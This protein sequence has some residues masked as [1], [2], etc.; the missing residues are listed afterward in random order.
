MKRLWWYEGGFGIVGDATDGGWEARLEL[1]LDWVGYGVKRADATDG[2]G[3]G[4]YL[5]VR[6]RLTI[7]T[8]CRHS[9]GYI[10]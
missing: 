8:V 10:H 3:R 6:N 5:S 2:R 9:R 1:E 7:H 4:G